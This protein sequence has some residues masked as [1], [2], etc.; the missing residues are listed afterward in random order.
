[1]NA[2]NYTN[3]N[4]IKYSAVLG[5]LILFNYFLW[6]INSWQ[7]LKYINFIFL[8]ITFIY[9]FVSKEYKDYWYLKII[10]ALL[11]LISL[12]TPT[13]ANDARYIYLFSGKILFYE[14]NLYMLL[15]NHIS[16]NNKYLHTFVTAVEEVVGLGDFFGFVGLGDSSSH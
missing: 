8:F 6:S 15:E 3:W 7:I 13:I 5:S 14:S 10:I 11:L 9:F 2:N 12:G 1:M 16:E 4:L